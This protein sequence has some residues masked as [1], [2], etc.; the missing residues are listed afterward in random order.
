MDFVFVL[1]QPW[2]NPFFFFFF[3]R[4][5]FISKITHFPPTTVCTL[6]ISSR[7]CTAELKINT[8]CKHMWISN[9]LCCDKV[10]VSPWE[11]DLCARGEDAAA[12][13]RIEVRM[14]NSILPFITRACV[15]KRPLALHRVLFCRT[16]ASQ[17]HISTR[18]VFRCICILCCRAMH[19]A[20]QPAFC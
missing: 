11:I 15:L 19:F 9:D 3:Y 12:S 1:F 17:T 6:S 14:R 2:I 18:A 8:D 10:D 16:H 20:R 7:W 13:A 4:I 5:C